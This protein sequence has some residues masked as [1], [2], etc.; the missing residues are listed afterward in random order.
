MGSH[1][2]KLSMNEAE[3]SFTLISEVIRKSLK[4]GCRDRNQLESSDVSAYSRSEYDLMVT[5]GTWSGGYVSGMGFVSSQNGISKDND[6]MQQSQNTYHCS[7]HNLSYMSV[8]PLCVE[9]GIHDFYSDPASPGYGGTEVPY[10]PYAGNY[11]G[12]PDITGVTRLPD[13]S[14]NLSSIFRSQVNGDSLQACKDMMA[15][16]GTGSYGDPYHVYQLK[17][18]GNGELEDFGSKSNFH[19]AIDCINRHLKDGR[20]IIAGI[21]HTLNSGQNEGTT[22]Q[23]VL[24]TGRGY[25]PEK[26]MYYFIYVDPAR[27]NA[28]DGCNSVENR[29]YCDASLGELY[30]NSTYMGKKFDVTQIRPNDGKK[31]DELVDSTRF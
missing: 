4:G 11:G 28:V 18:E 25:D 9:E 3:E 29:F 6:I 24:I 17:K 23:F 12:Y 8:C 13:M 2:K 22:D 14:M 1:F 7:K 26:R 16:Y 30:D 15:K 27:T 21:N 5:D 19:N 31:A 20:P 10:D